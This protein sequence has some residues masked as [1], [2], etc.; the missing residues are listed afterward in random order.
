MGNV[1]FISDAPEW[2]GEDNYNPQVAAALE[3]A[4]ARLRPDGLITGE[5]LV[6]LAPIL[7]ESMCKSQRLRVLYIVATCRAAEDPPTPALEPI[8]EA[9]ELTL[10]L[11]ETRAQVDLLL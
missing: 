7:K 9:L 2:S 5:A 6:C 10:E 3:C 1:W 11:N 8:D 4:L